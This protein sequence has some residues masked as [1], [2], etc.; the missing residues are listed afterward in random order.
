LILGS[1]PP[2]ME[3][4]SRCSVQALGWP[5][6]VHGGPQKGLRNMILERHVDPI[7]RVASRR[8]QMPPVWKLVLHGVM[9]GFTQTLIYTHPHMHSTW[10]R[11]MHPSRGGF[12]PRRFSGRMSADVDLAGPS[13]GIQV[14]GIYTVRYLLP[15]LSKGVTGL[16]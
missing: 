4:G 10:D 7:V 15:R 6:Y 13:H 14:L 5:P 8:A 1:Q 16:L 2:A 12:C 11:Y 9:C 3:T